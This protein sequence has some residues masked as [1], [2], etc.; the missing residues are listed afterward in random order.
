MGMG[1]MRL[2]FDACDL[3]HAP[4]TLSAQ[5]AA[6]VRDAAASGFSKN[7]VASL[8]AMHCLDGN[9][10]KSPRSIGRIMVTSPETGVPAV[11]R[12][13][14]CVPSR[15]FQQLLVQQ[16]KLRTSSHATTSTPPRVNWPSVAFVEA[17][18]RLAPVA[19]L[20]AV[21]VPLLEWDALP[22]QVRKGCRL[23]AVGLH[24][25]CWRLLICVRCGC[26]CAR[27]ARWPLHYSLSV[28]FMEAP[29]RL[30][31]VKCL[32]LFSSPSLGGSPCLHRCV[33]AVGWP[34][35]SSACSA[36]AG[37]Q[38]LKLDL[39]VCARDIKC[40]AFTAKGAH[41]MLSDV[42]YPA[43]KSTTSC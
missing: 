6:A 35:V 30:A 38:E 21:K 16:P 33:R 8:D 36:V 29:C 3:G 2:F 13:L 4:P 18:C 26:S 39:V 34:L 41:I 9:G 5:L 1:A 19:V 10:T 43:A 37:V 20:E 27:A 23:A 40:T 22:S 25:L 14:L 42:K 31:P 17:L 7:L 24:A 15:N 32:R 12:K 28:A 11:L